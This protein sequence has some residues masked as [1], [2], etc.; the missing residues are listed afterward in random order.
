MVFSFVPIGSSSY[1]WRGRYEGHLLPDEVYERAAELAKPEHVSTDRLVAAVVNRHVGDWSKMRERAARGTVEKL[2]R[3][4]A[5]VKD[6]PAEAAD[7][8]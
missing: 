5:K 7:Q 1:C 6:L 8:L 4:L 3:V 2:K